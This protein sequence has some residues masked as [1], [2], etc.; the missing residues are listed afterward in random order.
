MTCHWYLNMKMKSSNSLWQPALPL[1]TCKNNECKEH[2]HKCWGLQ[3]AIRGFNIAWR[4]RRREW[5]LYCTLIKC[6][7]RGR[8]DSYYILSSTLRETASG[9]FCWWAL[10]IWPCTITIRS[11]LL[12]KKNRGLELSLVGLHK[13]CLKWNIKRKL[14]ISENQFHF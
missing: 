12:K 2:T 1:W 6:S 13:L 9:S 4:H 8:T 11:H 7:T 14:E 5:R 10:L 3:F